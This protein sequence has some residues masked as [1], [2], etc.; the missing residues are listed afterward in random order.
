M[1]RLSVVIPH[2]NYGRFLPQCLDSII[3]QTLQPDEIIV[4]DGGSTD[5][6]FEVLKNYPTIKVVKEPFFSHHIPHAINLGL[7]E[8]KG[9]YIHV[10]N[11]DC[12]LERTFYEETLPKLEADERVG[13]V[14]SNW[15]YVDAKGELISS[16]RASDTFNRE[17]LLLSNYIDLM[18]GVWRRNLDFFDESVSYHY[19]WLMWVR[20]SRRFKVVSI[21]KALV[22]FRIHP[23][24]RA[25]DLE[26]GTD[27][28]L[29]KIK[30]EREEKPQI[31][32]QPKKLSYYRRLRSC[33]RILLKGT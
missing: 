1:L 33:A 10:G 21:P 32:E 29:A 13:L 6:T 8:A 26:Y 19:D 3:T 7:L 15:N 2:L 9:K 18:C 23:D 5:N 20:I 16:N 25:K 11:S 4:V 27:F 17:K 28:K 12:W 22:N 24:Q 31:K 30:I 14:Y